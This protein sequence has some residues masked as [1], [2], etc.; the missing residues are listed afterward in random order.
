MDTVAVASLGKVGE[1]EEAGQARRGP[2]YWIGGEEVQTCASR[3]RERGGEGG[4]GKSVAEQEQ[5][6]SK[7]ERVKKV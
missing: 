1:G 3:R 6:I 4:K 5:A 7:K 2:G